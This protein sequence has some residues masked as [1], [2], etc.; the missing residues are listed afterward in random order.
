MNARQNLLLVSAVFFVSWAAI[1]IRLCD[2]PALVIAFYRVGIAAVFI[3]PLV[4][5]KY[6]PEFILL[7]K[8]DWKL[9]ALAGIFLGLH[10]AFWISSLFYTS[11]ASSAVIVATQPVFA[12][13][14]SSIFLKEKSDWVTIL[15]IL[16]A[17]LGVYFIAQG[18]FR[19]DEKHLTGDLLSLIGAISAAAYLT[20]GRS[21]R[22]RHH[23][24]PYIFVVNLMAA[25]TLAVVVI[26]SGD[27]FSPLSGRNL[28]YFLLL[29]IIPSL[30]GHSLY[31]Y[32]L[33]YVTA[34]L[35]GISILGEPICATLW[36][37]L[38]FG[39]VPASTFYWGGGLIL[40]GVV[41]AVWQEGRVRLKSAPA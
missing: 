26:F 35:V 41:T 12:L 17:L 18:D 5:F 6:R 39:E 25:L 30:I 16:I 31:N 21:M 37:F 4:W 36:A 24:V 11:V 33:K 13:L 19:L 8:T 32:L 1:L 38:V 10:F 29:A 2:A 27:S 22:Q 20:V 15:A 23:F 28:F 14:F 3:F 34:Y 7:L 40:L 9:S